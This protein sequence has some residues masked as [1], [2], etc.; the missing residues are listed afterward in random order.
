M[1]DCCKK[2]QDKIA[3]TVLFMLQESKGNL[4]PSDSKALI[5]CSQI[6]IKHVLE[7]C[8]RCQRPLTKTDNNELVCFGCN[9]QQ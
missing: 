6:L 2:Y 5:L 8:Y 4:S 9:R 1:N 3:D 7:I